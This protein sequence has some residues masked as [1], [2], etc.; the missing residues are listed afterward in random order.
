M[1]DINNP[2][3]SNG[4]VTT[5]G[6]PA[7]GNLTKFSGSSSITSGDLSGD[8]TTSGTL[9]TTVAKILGVTV[10]GTTGTGNVVFSASPTFTGT[11][12]GASESLTGSLTINSSNT[13]STTPIF[14]SGS[15]GTT[16]SVKIVQNGDSSWLGMYSSVN[17]LYFGIST[18]LPSP[19]GT[20]TIGGYYNGMGVGGST[21]SGGNPIFGVL[22]SAQNS[23][24]LGGAA[25]TVYDNN[26]VLTFNTKLDDGSGNIVLTIAGKGITL[27]S[28]SNARIGT[29]TLSGGTLAVANNSVTANTRVFLTDT[30][31]GALTNV[32]SLTVVTSAGVGFT[33]S[34]T[35]VLDTSTFNWILFESS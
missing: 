31:S 5:T 3:S 1:S 18:K 35:N 23:N 29:G 15:V 25:F 12:S 33:V 34:S 27:K 30:T 19:T 11:I 14:Q 13:A 16:G 7:S 17:T 10:S 28:G 24:G 9:A 32:G 8:V 26:S 22:N 20:S 6:T 2:S 4:S 21:S